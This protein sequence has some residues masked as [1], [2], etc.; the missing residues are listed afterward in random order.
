MNCQSFILHGEK[1]RRKTMSEQKLHLQRQSFNK[2]N[3]EFNAMKKIMV[4]IYSQVTSICVYDELSH[5]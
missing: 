3:T 2:R 4:K 5:Q 1:H